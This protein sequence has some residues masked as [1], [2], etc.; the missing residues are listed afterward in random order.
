VD[1]AGEPVVRRDLDAAAWQRDPLHLL[2]EAEG[3]A[4]LA[5]GCQGLAVRVAR[6]VNRVLRRRGSL[7]ADRYHARRLA[8]PAEVRRALVYVLQ[9]WMKHVPG[10]CGLDSRSSAAWFTGWRVPV[11]APPGPA[12]VS[13]ART[14]LALVGW[15]R[16]GLLDH[17]E[18]PRMVRAPRGQRGAGRSP[19]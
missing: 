6:A 2:V 3:A 11:A 7:W 18:R 9:N 5:R 4:A 14:W 17:D 8:T 15:K 16:H 19:S 12:P 10:A 1:V 13:T